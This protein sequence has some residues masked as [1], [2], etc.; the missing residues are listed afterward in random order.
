MVGETRMIGA[1]CHCG[2]V[3]MQADESVDKSADSRFAINARCFA[4]ENLTSWAVRRFDRA[5]TWKYLD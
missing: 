2:T 4:L 1:G 3:V 5:N